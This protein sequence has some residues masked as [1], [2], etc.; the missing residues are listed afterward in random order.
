L[1]W[2]D[3]TKEYIIFILA[4]NYDKHAGKQIRNAMV[5]K[6]TQKKKKRKQVRF[7]KN[8]FSYSYKV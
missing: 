1:S 7:R 8:S 6:K 3:Q 2:R 4:S 5:E